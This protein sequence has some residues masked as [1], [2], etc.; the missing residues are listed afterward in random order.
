MEITYEG[1]CKKLGFDPLK[2]YPR[3]QNNEESS[4]LI[5][6]SKQSPFASLSLDELDFLAEYYQKHKQSI[7]R[8]S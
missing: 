6:D 4:W 1:I 2:D 7:N 3:K 8:S 5:D